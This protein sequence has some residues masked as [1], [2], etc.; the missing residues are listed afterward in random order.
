M[1]R[2]R[3]PSYRCYKPKNL[4][5]VVL[6]GKQHYLGKYGTPESVAEYNRLVQEWLT[7]GPA[8]ET[9]EVS[10]GAASGSEPDPG[11]PLVNELIVAFLRH[12]EG[13]YVRPDGIPS[14]EL[15]NLRSALKPLRK[16][17]G[18][19]PAATIGPLALRAIRD[20]MI[21]QGLSRTTI[22]ARINRIRRLFRW[23]SSTE[24]IPP[25]VFQSLQTV[26]GL[27]KGRSGVKEA[28]KVAPVPPQD[29]E[30]T[31]PYL[32]KPVAAMVRLQLLTGCRLG[33]VVVMRRMDLDRREGVWVY[34]PALHKNTWRGK[35][36]E[37]YL[38]PQARQ[39]VE[40]F[41]TEEPA[42]YLFSPRDVV[43]A[44][45]SRRS[46]ARQSK[47]TPSEGLRRKASPGLSHTDHY[48]RRSYRQA[49]VR[50]CKRAGVPS[51]SPLQLRHTAAT[52]IR[53]RYGL[54]AAQLFLGHEKADVTQIYAE[55]D[56]AKVRANAGLLP[57]FGFPTRVR[58][59]HTNWP[60]AAYPWPPEYGTI[61]R[62]LDIA[63]S[64]FAPK[65][66]TVRDKAVHT[67]CG[68]FAPQPVGNF[69][70]FEDGFAPPLPQPNTF[71]VRLCSSCQAVIQG[72][73]SL[74]ASSRDNLPDAEICPVCTE[75]SLLVVDAREPK[76]FFTDMAPRDY[77]GS[78]EWTP[79]S[80]RPSLSFDYQPDCVEEF[81]NA[82]V[83]ALPGRDI[84]TVND[85]GAERGFD[86]QAVRV[87][88]DNASPDFSDIP[89]AFVSLGDPA[90]RVMPVG[91][92]FCV[93]LLSR[94]RTDSLL[95]DIKTWPKG[96][97]ADPKTAVGR[98]AWYSFAFLLRVA[99]AGLLDAD[100][101]ELDAGFRTLP[102]DGQA[103][104][105]AFLC[106]K[107]ENGAGYCTRLS[108]LA[109]F[110]KLLEQAD[111]GVSES[112]AAKWLAVGHAGDCD[113]SCNLCL[114]DFYNMP[115]HG[116]LDWRLGLDMA[117]V[118]TTG[119]V[120]DL[121]SKWGNG[122]MPRR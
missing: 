60:Q 41:F 106:D 74:P 3:I 117:R 80:T 50:A 94:R 5:L 120:P 92:K 62:D 122:G 46:E 39:V 121:V 105:Q 11:S 1:P 72:G 29:V 42:K 61:D 19:T 4:G 109:E 84:I 57:M 16:L 67:A 18:Y 44:L 99:A 70:R 12:A 77:D 25:A 119:L 55:R 48:D 58:L 96:V 102:K 111:P 47:P 23:A 51:W 71:P 86:F 107:L 17:Y 113:T 13:H 89:R 116:L 27:Q 37:I 36:R 85:N 2:R 35:E 15:D 100:T 90:D 54:E 14:G 26:P 33:E 66:E 79:R 53:S 56:A 22:N 30:A 64:Q 45:H 115:Y 112:I 83:A 91:A 103:A 43:M 95:V 114:R 97:Y 32:P 38:G 88:T 76:G 82:E 9:P 49:I 31:L 28:P 21:D 101:L 75:Q 87:R 68:V 98:A 24:M 81:G 52:L 34:R 93:S 65:S 118:A 8:M 6:D 69:V 59:L 110:E 20:Q 10:G 73:A 108:N 7:R 78:F 104:A 40:E 63:I